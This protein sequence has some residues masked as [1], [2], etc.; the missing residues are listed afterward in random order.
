MLIILSEHEF[1]E[2]YVRINYRIKIS[3]LFAVWQRLTVKLLAY[4]C[5][6]K[7]VDFKYELM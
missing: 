1:Q 5:E 3:H 2:Q 6:G 7:E 4:L